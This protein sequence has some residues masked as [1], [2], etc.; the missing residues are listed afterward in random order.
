VH[1]KI[2]DKNG[3][4]AI[5]EIDNGLKIIKQNTKIMTN[6]YLN[7][8]NKLK[9]SKESL[10][11]FYTIQTSSNNNLNKDDIFKI[12]QKVSVKDTLYSVV[13]NLTTQTIFFKYKNQQI[14]NISLKDELYK[15]NQNIKYR[16]KDTTILP[17]K[18]SFSNLFI[19]P[20]F[21]YSKD[22][23]HFGTRVLLDIENNKRYGIEVTKFK[24]NKDNFY[25][26]GIIL[27]QRLWQWFNMS[28]GTI[29]YFSYGKNNDNIIGLTSNLGWEPD[30]HIP[31]KPFITYRNDLLFEKTHTKT[32]H[33]ISVGFAFAF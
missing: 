14:K 27:E 31:F 24:T 20:H 3:N 25:S 16:L 11:R 4:S 9:K 7:S 17:L 30:N 32:I 13:Y 33:S 26:I 28:I 22:Y 18:E 19:R 15:T 23:I 29:G 1:Y 2:V 10:K 12:L 21:G 5:V 8:K 6:H